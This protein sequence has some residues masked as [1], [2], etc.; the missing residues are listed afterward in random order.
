MKKILIS[1]MIIAVVAA[2]AIGGTVAFLTDSAAVGGNEITSGT[3]DVSVGGTLPIDIGPMVPGDGEAGVSAP[4]TRVVRITNDGDV[5]MYYKFYFTGQGNSAFAQKLQVSAVGDVNPFFG[6]GPM[7]S[8]GATSAVI[9]GPLAVNQTD[10]WTL[11]FWLPLHFGGPNGQDPVGNEV[12]GTTINATL[13]VQAVQS[14]N[15]PGMGF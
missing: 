9:V 11:Y 12:A 13:N 5:P 1:I 2:I 15:N 4:I 8:F 14:G 10:E 3:V 6:G 7:A